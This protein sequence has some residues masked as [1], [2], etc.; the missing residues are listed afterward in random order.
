MAHIDPDQRQRASREILWMAY[1]VQI[2]HGHRPAL[3]QLHAAARPRMHAMAMQVTRSHE[4][5]EEVVQDVFMYVWLNAASYD[6]SRSGIMTWMMMLCRS[7]ALDHLRALASRSRV[8]ADGVDADHQVD[9]RAGPERDCDQRQCASA[10]LAAVGSL[11]RHKRELLVLHYYS[12]LSYD[13]ISRQTA[14]PVA[15]VKTV[16]R[17]ACGG[18]VH[19]PLL[20][21]WQSAA[22]AC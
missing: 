19:H 14:M 13:E 2:A 21:P 20:T 12:D 5:A 6:A 7:R 17:R 15:T 3:Y 11:P 1:L 10:L 8:E 16:I 4:A 9:D 22:P 18:L